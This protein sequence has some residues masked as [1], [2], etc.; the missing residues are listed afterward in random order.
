MTEGSEVAKWNAAGGD[1]EQAPFREGF[2]DGFQM[3]DPLQ[4][5]V[6]YSTFIRKYL[7]ILIC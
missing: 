2:V 1:I 3:L 4:A 6:K 7:I 5:V